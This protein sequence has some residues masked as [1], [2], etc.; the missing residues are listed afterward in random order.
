MDAAANRA[1]N[2]FVSVG[3]IRR[4][5]VGDHAVNF[6]TRSRAAI[7]KGIDSHPPQIQDGG[8]FTTPD[9]YL[10]ARRFPPPGQSPADYIATELLFFAGPW[11][12]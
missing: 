3:L 10:G 6:M 8:Q 5:R 7:Q 1:C 2:R 11:M 9:V 12:K 4:W